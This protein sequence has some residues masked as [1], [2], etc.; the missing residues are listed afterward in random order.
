MKPTVF[1]IQ[2]FLNNPTVLVTPKK[3]DPFSNEFVGDIT[4]TR[5]GYLTVR[6]GDDNY[7]EVDLD[8]VES[9]P[10]ND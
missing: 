1:D 2:Y 9:F 3:D 6:D 10:E 4:G 8:Q 5:N 7:F